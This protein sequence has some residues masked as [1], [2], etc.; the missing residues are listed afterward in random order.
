MIAQGRPGRPPHAV[1]HPRPGSSHFPNLHGDRVLSK[2]VSS[3]GIVA[4]VDDNE[5]FCESTRRL[6]E[7]VNLDVCIFDNGSDFLADFDASGSEKRDDPLDCVVLDIEMPAP[8]GIDILDRLDGRTDLPPIIMITGFSDVQRA[9][10]SLTRGAF[11]FLEKPVEPALFI[12]RVSQAVEFGARQRRLRERTALARQ[13]FESLTPRET[14]IM[15]YLV[16]GHT[17]KEIAHRLS[18]SSK[19]VDT[20]RARILDKTGTNSVVELVWQRLSAEPR[21]LDRLGAKNPSRYSRS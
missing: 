5:I 8:N 18:L 3:K 16:R 13:R 9:V 14:E 19:T 7:S 15:E 4:L 6:L 17:A 20:H 21:L 11:D 2:A 1:R 10:G 12:E